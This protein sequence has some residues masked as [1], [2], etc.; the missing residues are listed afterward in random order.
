[1]IRWTEELPNLLVLGTFS[2][3]F[4]LAGLRVGYSVSSRE[5]ADQINRVKPYNVN[6][7]F[8]ESSHKNTG[9]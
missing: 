7:L 2:K 4:G 9:E 8:P 3:A 6:K 1:M 5:L